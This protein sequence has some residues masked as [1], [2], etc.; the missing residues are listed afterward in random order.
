MCFAAVCGSHCR[1]LGASSGTAR[2][3]DDFLGVSGAVEASL[4]APRYRRPA[5]F[6]PGCE[7][8]AVMALVERNVSHAPRYRVETPVLLPDDVLIT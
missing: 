8:L 5:L 7:S 4:P 1:K 6:Q 2:P 3:A